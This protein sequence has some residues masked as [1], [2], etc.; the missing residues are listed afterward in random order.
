[1]K[2]VYKDQDLE[3]GVLHAWVAWSKQG[4]QQICVFHSNVYLQVLEKEIACTGV[5]VRNE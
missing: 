2:D 1:M 5:V 3:N 4:L